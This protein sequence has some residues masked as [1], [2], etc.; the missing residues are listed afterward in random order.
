METIKDILNFCNAATFYDYKIAE[1]TEELNQV[2]KC[3]IN[4][5]FKKIPDSRIRVS[6]SIIDEKT[7]KIN[8]NDFEN[9]IKKVHDLREKI[10]NL[11]A[12][13]KLVR[14][15]QQI[16]RPFLNDDNDQD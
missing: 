11:I 1:I 16:V 12:F 5:F 14:D 6:L 13:E 2:N 3:L 8:N 4:S 10:L 9:F 15:E 7:L